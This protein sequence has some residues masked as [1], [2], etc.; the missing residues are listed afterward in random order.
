[1]YYA[2]WDTQCNRMMATGR[3]CQSKE[4]VKKALWSYNEPDREEIYLTNNIDDVSLELL[5]EVGEFLLMEQETPFDDI[6]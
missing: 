2:L 6:D 3:N 5:L 1:M 4:D